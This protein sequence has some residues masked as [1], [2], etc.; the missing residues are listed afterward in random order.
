[1]LV[2]MTENTIAGNEKVMFQKWFVVE[3]NRGTHLVLQGVQFGGTQYVSQYANNLN[4]QRQSTC[5][6]S[7]NFK[8]FK[9]FTKNS[10][11]KRI[12]KK[13]KLEFLC[14]N[15]KVCKFCVESKNRLEKSIRAKTHFLY[16]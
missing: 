14:N 7:K 5:Q 12:L 15:K 8:L 4:I 2:F 9:K 3:Q 13:F 6:N 1:M 11:K 10:L 16:V